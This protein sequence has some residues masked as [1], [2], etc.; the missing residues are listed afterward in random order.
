MR[1]DPYTGPT[2]TSDFE[3]LTADEMSELV[4]SYTLLG[5]CFETTDADDMLG[6][7]YLME[8]PLD[9]LKAKHERLAQARRELLAAVKLSRYKGQ[10][11]H[12]I[13]AVLGMSWVEAMKQFA[14]LGR[15]RDE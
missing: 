6:R 14:A 5:E 4:T 13:G 7:G 2:N 1:S 8:I 10:D 3:E 9:L 12:E 15:E 11:W